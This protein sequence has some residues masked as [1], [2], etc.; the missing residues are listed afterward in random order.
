MPARAGIAQGGLA[1]FMFAALSVSARAA[2]TA[3]P[4][5]AA[6][7]AARGRRRAR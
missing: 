1:L 3:P 6:P 4:A 7:P 5:T 2:E